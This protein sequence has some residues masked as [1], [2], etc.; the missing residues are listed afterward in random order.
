MIWNGKMSER[1][2]RERERERERE[3]KGD[4]NKSTFKD[5]E[6]SFGSALLS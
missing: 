1:E 5:G 6:K 3:W 4:W 2:R